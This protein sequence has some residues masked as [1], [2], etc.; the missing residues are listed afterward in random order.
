[1]SL[2]GGRRP[3]RI[4]RRDAD[5]AKSLAIRADLSREQRLSQLRCKAHRPKAAILRSLS[6]RSARRGAAGSDPGLPSSGA[7]ENRQHARRQATIRPATPEAQR[8]RAATA[9]QQRKAA[10]AWRDDVSLEGVDLQRDILPGLQSVPVSA[11]AEA[12]GACIS[13]GPKVRCGHTV[14]HKRHWSALQKLT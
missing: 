3:S 7:G 12:M 14:L 1:V 4:G 13:H 10:V 6:T 11:I 2:C 9:S 8:R 5:D